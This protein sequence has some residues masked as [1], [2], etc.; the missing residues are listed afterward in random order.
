MLVKLLMLLTQAVCRTDAT[1]T[2]FTLTNQV[3]VVENVPSEDPHSFAWYAS[4]DDE[5]IVVRTD[6]H[7]EV[8]TPQD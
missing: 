6:R 5:Q 4:F 2:C 3:F 8:A 1:P 7:M